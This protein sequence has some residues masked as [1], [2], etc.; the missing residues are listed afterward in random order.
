MP[1]SY[2]TSLARKAKLLGPTVSQALDEFAR[3]VAEDAKD[4]APVGITGELQKSIRVE[5]VASGGKY[6]DRAVVAGNDKAYYANMVEGGSATAGRG[7]PPQPPRPFL[8]PA[9]E[10]NKRWGLLHVR[11]A[12]Q[13]MGRL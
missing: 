4:R 9:F 10:A 5:K 6:A 13:R 8:V 12:L 1:V 11:Q 2:K 7:R 3:K